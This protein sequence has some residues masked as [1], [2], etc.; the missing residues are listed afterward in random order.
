MA[1]DINEDLKKASNKTGV[2]KT[3]KEYK[4]SYESLKK[5]AGSSQETAN[6]FLSQPLT[7]YKKWRKKHTANAKTFLDELIQQLKQTK[8]S[9]VET[10]KLIKRIFLN[11]LKK[12]KP[13]LKTILIEEAIKALGC[14]NTMTTIPSTYYVPVRCVDLFGSFELGPD[15][16]IGKFFYEQ[17]P[18]Q[19]NDF[20]FSMNRE[21]YQR[22]Q[23]LNQP[24]QAVAGSPYRG[25]SNQ[26][27]F[28]VTYIETYTDPITLLPVNEPTFKVDISTRV[29]LPAVDIFLA[30]YYESIDIL[31]Y[32]QF[33]ANLTDYVTGV[34]SFGRGDGFLKIQTIQ[35][36]LLIM[37]RILGL[38][39][40][41]NKEINVGASSKVFQT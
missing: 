18:I 15:D 14:S 39:S 26:N 41:S 34:I 17:K 38:C 27:L 40:D 21:L 31:D 10:D 37:Q 8:G 13:Q 33:F 28:N 6:K 23:N 4:K 32:K 7:D 35:K 12:I 5:K 1:V 11:S 22:T 36:V 29:G 16:K 30:D 25:K 19:Y 3:Y 24:Y 20:P 9:G 2:Y